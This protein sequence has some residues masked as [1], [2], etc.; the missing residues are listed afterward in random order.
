MAQGSNKLQGKKKKKI[1]LSKSV[2]MGEKKSKIK[3]LK[4]HSK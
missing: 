3:K 4:Q 2:Q 1:Y